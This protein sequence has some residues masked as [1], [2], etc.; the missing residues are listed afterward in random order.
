MY[1]FKRYLSLAFAVL[2]FAGC[3]EDVIPITETEP[4]FENEQ[5][6]MV[7]VSDNE[8]KVNASGDNDLVDVTLNF[9]TW[10][11]DQERKISLDLGEDA[12]LKLIVRSVS[13]PFQYGSLYSAYPQELMEDRNT[14]LIA[15]FHHKG[16]LRYATT[17]NGG[18]SLIQTNVMEIR[19]AMENGF[20]AR[21]YDLT[22][23]KVNQVED[24]RTFSGETLVVNGTFIAIF[25]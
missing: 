21:I 20:S 11:Y 8:V 22:L 7:L 12:V 25:D 5:I 24:G 9:P 19:R 6:N 18:S 1:I 14:Y 15:Q 3:D 16:V 10:Y 13:D 23:D 2:L 4:L 17:I